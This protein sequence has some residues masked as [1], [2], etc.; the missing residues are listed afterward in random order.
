MKVLITG[1][2]GYIGSHTNRLFCENLAE[3][4]VLDD[5]SMGHSEAVICGKLVKG[6]MGDTV[7][8][9]ELFSAEKFDAIV[10]F[11][12]FTSVGESVY[13]PSKYYRNNISNMV[14]LLDCAV[15]FN[16]KYFIFSSSAAIFGEPLY[17]PIDE[18]HA[19]DPI[20][21]YGT[22]KLFGEKI[23][24]DYEKA[25][26]LKYCALRY[27]NAAGASKD[28]VIGE[29]HT[30]ETHI[31]PIILKAAI[32]KEH[33]KVFGADYKTR[34]GS[35]LRDYIHV[36]DLAAAHYKG[37]EYIMETNKSDAFNMGTAKG[38]TVLELIKECEKVTGKEIMYDINARREGDPA[39]LIASNK[40]AKDI[41]GI[42]PQNTITQIISDA[43]NWEQN[44]RY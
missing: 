14:N 37:L 13:S 36:E 34:D 38:N 20:N 31:I 18:E 6:N 35:C 43:W 3:T 23:L 11:A 22:T 15:K 9:E 4:V 27:F 33:I 26:G 39:S 2:A 28:S 29:S 19:K 5:L 7:M 32:N 10:N 44:K 30:P 41:L 17:T 40:K 21:P 24:A 8:L 42:E 25:Y 1:G 12:G 16:V